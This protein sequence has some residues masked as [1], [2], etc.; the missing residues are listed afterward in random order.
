MCTLVLGE[1]SA[2]SS[3]LKQ[4]CCAAVVAHTKNGF[5]VSELHTMCSM[6]TARLSRLHVAGLQAQQQQ[7]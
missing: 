5:L 6:S 3:V 4:L 1:R 7:A 2:T